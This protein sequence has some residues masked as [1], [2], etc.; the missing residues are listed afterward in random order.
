MEYESNMDIDPLVEGMVEVK[1]SKETKMCIREPWSKALIVKVF[2]R[3]VGF[4]YLTFKINALWKP[5]ARMDCV[6]LG[7]G[8]LLIRFSSSE[9]YDKFLRGGPWFV[10]EHFLAIR[11]WEPYFKA[12][13]D[14]LSLVVVWVKLPKLPIEFYDRE[15]L[16][17]IG[18]AIGPVLRI[19]S[20]TASKSRG[21]YARLCIQIDLEK[22]LT[23]WNSWQGWAMRYRGKVIQVPDEVIAQI[24]AA[25]M[26]TIGWVEEGLRGAWKTMFPLTQESRK[27]GY[28]DPDHPAW[29]IT[30][31]PW[32]KFLTDIPLISWEKAERLNG[33]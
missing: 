14:K 8:F 30:P 19:D 9:D 21:S 25:P 22:P 31:N 7:K 4:N 20:Y 11:P 2:G 12:S 28:L 24:R 18:E 13:E 15:V 26:D 1:L 23:K 16:K 29:G 17:K 10:G 27:M 5:A 32:W 6:N 3:T 33:Q